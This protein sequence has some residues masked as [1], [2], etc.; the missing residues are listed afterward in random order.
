MIQ[1]S[2]RSGG[3]CRTDRTMWVVR[4]DEDGDGRTKMGT[5][6]DS[7]CDRCIRIIFTLAADLMNLGC[8]LYWFVFVYSFCTN[9][10]TS[11]FCCPVAFVFLMSRLDGATPLLPSIISFV[12]SYALYEMLSSLTQP[13]HPRRWGGKERQQEGGARK[14]AP[15]QWGPGLEQIYS[16]GASH[17]RSMIRVP[18]AMPGRHP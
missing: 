11:L 5:N 18:W 2:V 10:G 15:N 3:S 4:S 16:T 12:C 8:M 13:R 17:A 7:L 9:V 1:R 14:C 6:P